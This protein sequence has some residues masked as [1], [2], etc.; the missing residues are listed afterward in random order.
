LVTTVKK[1][2]V[3]KE[4]RVRGRGGEGK[5][6]NEKE[7]YCFEAFSHP[8]S[9]PNIGLTRPSFFLTTLGLK[10]VYVPR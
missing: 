3:H 5:E 4:M 2:E 8:T 1:E 7:K 6:E 9:A 10:T